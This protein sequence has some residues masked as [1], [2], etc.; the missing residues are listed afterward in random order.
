MDNWKF[1]KL[2]QGFKYNGVNN[3]IFSENQMQK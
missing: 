2:I 3:I 1:N